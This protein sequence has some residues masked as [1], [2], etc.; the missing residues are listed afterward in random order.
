MIYPEIGLAE[1]VS[2][3]RI[4]TSIKLHRRVMAEAVE[5]SSILRLDRPAGALN[6][7]IFLGT[8]P[9]NAPFMGNVINLSR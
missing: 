3:T 6:D 2:A 1:T 9:V 8:S 7:L 4:A 5:G